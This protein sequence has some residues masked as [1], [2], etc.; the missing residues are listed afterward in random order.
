M[1][2]SDED[3]SSPVGKYQQIGN[4]QKKKSSRVFSGIDDIDD[5]ELMMCGEDDEYIS[6][7]GSITK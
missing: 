3:N 4:V 2:G 6:G 1:S 7:R 5:D